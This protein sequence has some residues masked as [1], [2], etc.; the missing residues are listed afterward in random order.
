MPGRPLA[1][2]YFREA[3]VFLFLARNE[4][5]KEEE[6][7]VVTFLSAASTTVLGRTCSLVRDA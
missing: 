3:E 5:K 1:R 2:I 6:R 4:R 7:K